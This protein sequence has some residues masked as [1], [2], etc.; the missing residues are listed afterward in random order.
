MET[1]FRTCIF[2]P[3][4]TKCISCKHGFIENGENFNEILVVCGLHDVTEEFPIKSKYVIPKKRIEVLLYRHGLPSSHIVTCAGCDHCFVSIHDAIDMHV[5][6]YGESKDNS[7]NNREIGCIHSN[8][9]M[10]SIPLDAY[11]HSYVPTQKMQSIEAEKSARA[12]ITISKP[13]MSQSITTRLQEIKN[14]C[15][16]KK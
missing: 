7:L 13:K 15:M 14:K 12:I 5:K 3:F 6:A 1:K 4:H 8:G 9:S 11:R 2:T 10:R 16:H